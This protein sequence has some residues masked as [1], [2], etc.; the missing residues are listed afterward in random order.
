MGLR[1]ALGFT[2]SVLSTTADVQVY[3]PTI[4]Q[5]GT[6]DPTGGPFG[7]GAIRTDTTFD[8]YSRNFDV[9]G[10]LTNG[11]VIRAFCYF[12]VTTFSGMNDDTR[13]LRLGTNVQGVDTFDG[14]GQ[15]ALFVKLNGSLFVNRHGTNATVPTGGTSIAGI[16]ATGTW[17]AI[18]LEAKLNTVANGGYCKV[19]VFNAA[20]GAGGLV[21]DVTASDMNTGTVPSTYTGVGIGIGNNPSKQWSYDDIIC[22]DDEG[23]DF[24]GDKFATRLPRI[25]E[26]KPNGH[27]A[28]VQF[29]PGPE[30]NLNFNNVSEAASDGD[31]SF[32]SGAAG[33]VDRFT[34]GDLSAP[35]PAEVFGLAHWVVS[36]IDAAGTGNLRAQL[37]SNAVVSE[38]AD[39]TQTLSYA[40]YFTPYG[41]DPE[42][43]APW[44][45]PKACTGGSVT[46]GYK[47]QSIA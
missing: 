17:Y 9:P 43:S 14:N 1:C 7:D 5:A 16:I 19:K 46:S 8:Y 15:F 30:S 18:V 38:S 42:T 45:V 22:W 33:Q 10:N 12:R 11:G 23:T 47:C 36:K 4:S 32:N 13:F 34:L 44:N 31:T 41:Q 3:L 21:I 40:S 25:F 37:A 35:L 2:N 27:S 26:R 39:K 20:T 28:T 6:Y 29:T 24:V